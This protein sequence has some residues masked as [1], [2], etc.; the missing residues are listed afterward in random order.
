MWVDLPFRYLG[1]GRGG[2][3]MMISQSKGNGKLTGFRGG[4]L[5]ISYM[6]LEWRLQ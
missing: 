5:L 2:V 6:R 3:N 4:L 1:K